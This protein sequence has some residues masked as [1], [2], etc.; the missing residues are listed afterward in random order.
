MT[1]YV[2]PE[3]RTPVT[4]KAGQSLA[5]LHSK[6]RGA[7][8]LVAAEGSVWATTND[9]SFA[10]TTP[11]DYSPPSKWGAATDRM[12][13]QQN[14]APLKFTAE[15]TYA[16][17]MLIT[18][19]LTEHVYEPALT[20]APS[21]VAIAKGSPFATTTKKSLADL[22]PR[23]LLQAEKARLKAIE[24]RPTIVAAMSRVNMPSY[25]GHE[26]QSPKNTRGPFVS[27][28]DTTTGRANEQGVGNWIG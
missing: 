28:V 11:E 18:N 15:T 13:A 27:G 21:E 7:R 4:R 26:P 23:E 14:R 17:S 5:T 16:A 9:V 6:F 8:I 1:T 24:K 22:V 10:Q 20:M 2:S 25:T 12:K 19:E 3:G